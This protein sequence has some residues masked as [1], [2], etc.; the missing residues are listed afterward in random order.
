VRHTCTQAM[1]WMLTV[2]QHN[3]TH[4]DTDGGWALTGG[5]QKFGRPSH[6]TP[7]TSRP[8][9]G[10]A[11]DSFPGYP[12][13]LVHS[14]IHRLHDTAPVNAIFSGPSPPRTHGIARPSGGWP[15]G[16]PPWNL[17][18]SCTIIHAL[19]T[20]NAMV[21]R[22]CLTEP[23]MDEADL[24]RVSPIVCCGVVAHIWSNVWPSL[25][26]IQLITCVHVCLTTGPS[27]SSSR[28]CSR[29]YSC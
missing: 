27:C 2:K 18:R 6:N 15:C 16:T 29:V 19:S 28:H 1:S 21:H 23:L 25:V 8:R 3:N 11:R 10:S 5:G 24:H 22:Y 14:Y 17:P 20:V 7:V 9:V 4:T 26:S 13:M 12:A